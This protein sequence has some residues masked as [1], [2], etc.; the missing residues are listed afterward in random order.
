MNERAVEY[1]SDTLFSELGKDALDYIYGRGF[2][3]ETIRAFNIGYAPEKGDLKKYIKEILTNAKKVKEYKVAL[4]TMVEGGL[5]G[6]G[7]GNYKYD[8]FVSRLIFPINDRNERC[9]ALGGRR[10]DEEK[11][12]GKYINTKET[13]IFSKR[14]VFYG[15][16]KAVRAIASQKKALIV[17]GY[18]DVMACHQAG[19][20]NAIA[21]LGTAFTEHHAKILK[22]LGCVAYFAFDNDLAGYQAG[23][24]SIITCVENELSCKIVQLECEDDYCKYLLSDVASAAFKKKPSRANLELMHPKA[25]AIR[26]S[27][28]IAVDGFSWLIENSLSRVSDDIEKFTVAKKLVEHIA[29]GEEDMIKSIRL[30][31]IAK[32]FDFPLIELKSI[33]LKASASKNGAGNTAGDVG[34]GGGVYGAG[35]SEAVRPPRPPENKVAFN[36]D[37]SDTAI[38]DISPEY[39]IV[40][41]RYDLE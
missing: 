5:A 24:K 18:T 38:A 31:A 21:V 14:K 39:R 8:R 1:Y 12:G 28:E 29:C 27:I 19:I 26:D 34:F 32:A 6:E 15:L 16:E 23:K 20:D 3:E 10:L 13:A 17:E 35:R 7:G 40:P 9:I 36:N 33:L 22:R 41:Y 25:E 30:K 2:S 37:I 4:A 11:A